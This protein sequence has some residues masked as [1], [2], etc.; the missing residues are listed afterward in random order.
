MSIVMTGGGTGGHL[1]IIKAVKEHLNGEEL[2]YIGSTK[3]QDRQW[4]EHDDDFTHK[5]FFETRGVVNQGALGKVKSLFMMFK[6]TMK[7]IKLLR[8]HKAKVVFSVGGFSSAATAFAA[9]IL[10]IPLVIHEQNAALGSLNKLLKP[11]ASV[12][13]SSYLEESPIKAYPIKQIF[14][15]N[16]RIRDRV[17]TIIFLGGSQGAKAINRLALQIAPQLKERGIKII[18]QAGQ[19]NIDE[20]QKAYDGLDIE[21]EVFGFTDRLADYMKEADLAIAR[22]GA[23]TLWELSATAVPTLYIPYPFAASDHQFHNAQ[24]LVEKELAWIMRED[25]IDTEKVLALLNEDLSEKSKGLMEIVE[26]N[27]SEKIAELLTQI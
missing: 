26:K 25:E 14:F 23:S 13:I 24:F 11:H 17:G 4:F 19:N 10:R 15:D 18:H 7:A 21:A 16:A 12:F 9:K 20:V 8:K 2:I 1:A 22:S 6:A 3:G 5:Y 27:G